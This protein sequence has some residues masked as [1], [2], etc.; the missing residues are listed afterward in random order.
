MRPERYCYKV[1]SKVIEWD[2]LNHFKAVRSCEVIALSDSYWLALSVG[3][4]FV[5]LTF[6]RMGWYVNCS[7]WLMNNVL[8]EQKR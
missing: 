3:L 2:K 1:M 5:I 4:L 8:F 7:A 6:K